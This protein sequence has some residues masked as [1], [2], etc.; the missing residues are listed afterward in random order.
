MG[1]IR[2]WANRARASVAV[3]R[4]LALGAALVLGLAL[5]V[6]TTGVASA[7]ASYV[8]ST[9]EANAVVAAAPTT[10]TIHFAEHVNPSGSA[11]VVLDSKGT[12][13]STDPARVD[14]SDLT[15]MTVNMKGDDSD[16]YLVQWHTVSADDGEPD[17][18]AF[19]FT[20]GASGT[21]TATTSPGGT[22]GSGSGGSGSSGS[23]GWL[24][25]LVGVLGLVIGGAGGMA[26]AR[27][28]AR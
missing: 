22:P 17:I 7:H 25:A 16:V 4:S 21:P 2:S 6:G 8:S 11:V 26:L 12:A 5:L 10:I 15:V 3:R 24:V 9:P 20:V 14:P 28:S 1:N 23:S 13:V 18:G 27:R 19:T